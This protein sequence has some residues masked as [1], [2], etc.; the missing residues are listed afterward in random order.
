SI[1]TGQDLYTLRLL[2]LMQMG[3]WDDAFEL[4]NKGDDPG[5]ND[6]LAEIG[7]LLALHKK[8]LAAACLDY[9]AFGDR[10]NAL[11]FKRIDLIC[12]K[13]LEDIAII[14]TQFPKSTVLKGIYTDP[15]FTFDAN[16]LET[17]KTFTFL[18]V[19]ML[20][21]KNRLTYENFDLKQDT[22]PYLLKVFLEDEN[23]PPTQKTKLNTLA[24]HQSILPFIK[25][26]ENSAYDIQNS[27][28]NEI[29]LHIANLIE[30]NAEI[31][32]KIIEKLTENALKN[33]Q[34]IF[35]LQLLKQIRPKLNIAEF[36]EQEKQRALGEFRTEFTK[37]VNILNSWLDK[38]SEFSNNPAK[39]YEKQVIKTPDGSYTTVSDDWTN[40]LGNATQNQYS[41]ISLLIVLNNNKNI[42]VRSESMIKDL[43][44]VGLIEQAHQI[45]VDMT[46]NLMRTNK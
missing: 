35:Y 11:F 15:K 25:N 33:P 30:N 10:F 38:R 4:Y 31:S 5:Q 29:I 42:G 34:N 16:D 3:L 13:E 45:G 36:T 22:P 7:I 44:H 17:L 6:R 40:W 43:R 9:K 28:Q 1:K 37:E 23:F 26:D 41:G 39:V 21:E 12:G 20:L 19:M 2:K 32:P 46:V 27:Q 14:S 18:E 24:K 8:G